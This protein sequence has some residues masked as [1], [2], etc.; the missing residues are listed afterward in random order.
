MEHKIFL[1][2]GKKP[3]GQTGTGWFR[4]VMKDTKRRENS[5]KT[6]KKERLGRWKTLQT[7]IHPFTHSVIHSF[8]HI[9]WKRWY[10]KRRNK[11]Y[12]TLKV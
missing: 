11:T 10:K 3:T 8:I 7:F 1:G 9:K 6:L 4:Q 5:L 12:Y 2:K